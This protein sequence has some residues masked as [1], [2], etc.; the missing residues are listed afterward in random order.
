MKSY[1]SEA[2]KVWHDEFVYGLECGR[3]SFSLL[4]EIHATSLG[5]SMYDVQPVKVSKTKYFM[6][7]HDSKSRNISTVFFHALH[8]FESQ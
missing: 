4:N 7:G 6:L 2:I 5:D 8:Q 1:F 3:F